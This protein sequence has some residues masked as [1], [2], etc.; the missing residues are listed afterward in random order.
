M[1]RSI[2]LFLTIL[3]SHSHVLLGQVNVRLEFNDCFFSRPVNEVSCSIYHCSGQFLGN[4]NSKKNDYITIDIRQNG[5]Y[6]LNMI[7]DQYLR[8]DTVVYLSGSRKLRLCLDYEVV[9]D[10]LLY[11]E[12]DAYLDIREGEPKILV[13]DSHIGSHPRITEYVKKK[14]GFKYQVV[15]Y[16]N[17]D[18]NIG[19]MEYSIYRYNRVVDM[20]LDS[21]HGVAWKDS[22]VYEFKGILDFE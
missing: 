8:S 12:D 18:V 11:S 7:K 14:Y 17:P 21:L 1:P 15:Y 6:I 9:G 10:S 19:L 5:C 22:L 16:G 2:I 3:L 20:Y 13:H 4:F